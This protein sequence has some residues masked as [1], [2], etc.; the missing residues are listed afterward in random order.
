MQGKATEMS[1]A[2]GL[3]AYL[4]G[5]GLSGGGLKAGGGLQAKAQSAGAS[6]S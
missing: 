4:S 1:Y 5:G 3:A 6:S 2:L